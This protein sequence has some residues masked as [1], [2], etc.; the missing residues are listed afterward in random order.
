M[1]HCMPEGHIFPSLLPPSYWFTPLSFQLLSLTVLSPTW[2]TFPCLS[3]KHCTE[4]T[5]L[6]LS[7]LS[8]SSPQ[9]IP[10]ILI[11]SLI[12]F[13]HLSSKTSSASPLICKEIHLR[14][15]QSTDFKMKHTHIRT[16][17]HLIVVL[18][19]RALLSILAPESS[20]RLPLRSTFR[21]QA[22]EPRALTSTMP[23]WRSLE[24]A[25]ERDCRAWRRT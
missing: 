6:P 15:H 17:T 1:I 12:P 19:C 25:R 4:L 23:R 16:H 13:F 10:N 11:F 2:L 8:V 22:L 18:I 24:S 5:V 21:R 14:S 7:N 3:L 20:R 9:T